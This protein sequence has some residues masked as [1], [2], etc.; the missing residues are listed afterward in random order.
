MK[1]RLR[2]LLSPPPAD[3]PTRDYRRHQLATDPQTPP[4]A[5]LPPPS[6]AEAEWPTVT[7][8]LTALPQTQ[9][10]L[11]QRVR[12]LTAELA[13]AHRAAGLAGPGGA[14]RTGPTPSGEE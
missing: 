9:V 3:T 6:L 13:H 5:L 14:A 2:A 1:C 10:T 4:R 11:E 7:D 12:E 8:A